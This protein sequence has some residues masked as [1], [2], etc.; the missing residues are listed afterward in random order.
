[1]KVRGLLLIRGASSSIHNSEA[2][3]SIGSIRYGLYNTRL[4]RW[5]VR[6]ASVQEKLP[7]QIRCESRQ[8]QEISLL[9]MTKLLQLLQAT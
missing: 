3:I 9:E 1:M 7:T 5:T 6:S 8:N 2:R 4:R